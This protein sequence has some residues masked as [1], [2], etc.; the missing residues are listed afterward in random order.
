[1]KAELNIN[2]Q[3]LEE[4]VA[5]RVVKALKPLLSGKGED[6]NLFTVKGLA[7]YLGISQKWVYERVQFKEIPYYKLGGSLRFKKSAIDR[8]LE[9]TCKTPAVN[10][11]AGPLK[12]VK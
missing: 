10:S 9:E 5:Q 1:M 3:E 7:E 11:P 12:A 4:R 6:H 8:W 2:T